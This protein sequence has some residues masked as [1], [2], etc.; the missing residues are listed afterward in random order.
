MKR[1]WQI[2]ELS[3]QFAQKTASVALNDGAISVHVHFP[4]DP[5][6]DQRESEVQ[7]RAIRAAK[8]LLREA[9]E[10]DVRPVD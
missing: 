2:R 5:K 1:N 3:V 8:D 4:F 9:S 7:A 6:G 10:A